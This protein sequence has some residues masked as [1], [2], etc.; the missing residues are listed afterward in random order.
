VKHGFLDRYSDLESPLHSLSAVAKVIVFF[1]IIVFVLS[2]RAMAYLS[3]GGYFVFLLVC[4]G[5]S[6]VPP[7]HVL[8][9]S[10]MVIPFVAF[11]GI[12]LLFTGASG[13][14]AGGHREGLV[15]FQAIVIKSYVSIFA[16]VLLSAI[17]PFPSFLGALHKLGAPRIIVSLMSFTYRYLFLMIEELERMQR[18]RDARCF[19]GKWAWHVKTVGW[20]IGTFFVRSYE[21]AERVYQA[22]AARGF[23]GRVP[24]TASHTMSAKDYVFVVGALTVFL[25]LRVVGVPRWIL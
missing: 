21:R 22:M 3:F 19:G 8:R 2:C 5:L 16:L 14:E 13:G 4:L 6:H 23:D 12:S 15:L 10:L 25:G 20:M 1:A 7:I 11:A 9:R 17:T 18:A 24:A